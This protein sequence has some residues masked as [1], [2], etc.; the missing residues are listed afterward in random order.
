MTLASCAPTDS[1][2]PSL[3]PNGW[4]REARPPLEW[5]AGM[6]VPAAR[7][8]S[9]V[10]VRVITIAPGIID[11]PI[12]GFNPDPEAFKAALAAPIPALSRVVLPIETIMA[13][14]GTSPARTPKTRTAVAAPA[15][16]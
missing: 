16:A 10:G 12:Y 8:L 5:I 4:L 9:A 15:A 2:G 3:Y 14:S 6:T 7:D 13:A 1:S 11:T